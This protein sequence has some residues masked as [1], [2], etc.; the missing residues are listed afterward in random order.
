VQIVPPTRSL[1][2][3]LPQI[4]AQVRLAVTTTTNFVVHCCCYRCYTTDGIFVVLLFCCFVFL[5]CCVSH[6]GDSIVGGGGGAPMGGPVDFKAIEQRNAARGIRPCKTC[7]L[8]FVRFFD[9]TL[10]FVLF[11]SANVFLSFCLPPPQAPTIT[12]ATNATL[13]A[14]G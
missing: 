5:L 3:G 2:D 14:I 4:R 11:S 10:V 12:P 8:P 9:P 1:D 7:S 6:R 13:K